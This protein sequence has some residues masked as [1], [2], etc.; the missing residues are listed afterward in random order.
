VVRKIAA[1]ETAMSG[2]LTV[3]QDDSYV[4][5]AQVDRSASDLMLVEGFR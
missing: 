3:T 1:L 5:W 2:G 4:V